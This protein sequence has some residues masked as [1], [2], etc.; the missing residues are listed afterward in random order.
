M[1]RSA[2]RRGSL[3]LVLGFCLLAS[4]AATDQPVITVETDAKTNFV[5]IS[6]AAKVVCALLADGSL[7]VRSLADGRLLKTMAL[8]SDRYS[9]VRFT[10]D[11]SQL[12][13]ATSNGSIAVWDTKSLQQ[14]R[15][16]ET[17]QKEVDIV[18]LDANGKWLVTGQR[19][20]IKVWDIASGK[21]SFSWTLSFGEAWSAAISPDGHALVLGT[22]DAVV[23]LIEVPS[24]KVLAESKELPLT[25]LF[26]RY[27]EDGKQILAGGAYDDVVLLSA[28]D[29][30][31]SSSLGVNGVAVFFSYGPAKD[32]LATAFMNV[33]DMDQPPELLV[34]T[35]ASPSKEITRVPKCLGMDFEDAHHILAAVPTGKGFT[36]QRLS[37]TPPPTK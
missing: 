26:L 3:P 32:V 20:A 29:L 25:T 1:R 2:V 14:L 31:K 18:T 35:F 15:T 10:P 24:G 8:K 27:T 23:H 12:L 9:Y 7:Q 17:G 22:T 6:T 16:W 34:S 33:D 21:H 13:T 28:V 19:H 30:K 5:G 36:I 4:A 11:G 37:V